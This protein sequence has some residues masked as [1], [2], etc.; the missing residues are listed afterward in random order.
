MDWWWLE[1]LTY[2]SIVIALIGLFLGWLI[3]DTND[4]AAFIVGLILV[5]PFICNMLLWVVYVIAAVFVAIW[6]PY[7]G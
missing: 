1:P 5:L 3:H 7:I 2:T 4:Y 6:S